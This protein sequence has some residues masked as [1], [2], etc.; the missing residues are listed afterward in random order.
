MQ[1]RYGHVV[2]RVA[3]PKD[4]T[5]TEKTSTNNR[6]EK[7]T[8]HIHRNTLKTNT[9][10]VP[11]SAPP[12][13]I[14]TTLKLTTVLTAAPVKN[15]CHGCTIVNK[16]RLLCAHGERRRT[17]ANSLFGTATSTPTKYVLIAKLLVRRGLISVWKLGVLKVNLNLSHN[18]CCLHKVLDRLR[19]AHRS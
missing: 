10:R 3:T 2:T 19:S 11:P 9:F 15:C 6:A 4:R 1:R 14:S 18:P 17:P 12:I 7:A 5:I 8:Q 13:D 16:K